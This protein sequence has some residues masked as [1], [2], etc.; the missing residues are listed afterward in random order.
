MKFKDTNPWFQLMPSITSKISE[1]GALENF[2]DTHDGRTTDVV[3]SLAAQP[4]GK[5]SSNAAR[6]TRNFPECRSTQQST[7][8]EIAT[9]SREQIEQ[10]LAI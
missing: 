2:P 5:K 8:E 9:D 6:N 7:S 4:A 10:H 3:S 1:N